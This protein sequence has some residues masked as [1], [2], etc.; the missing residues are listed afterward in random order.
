MEDSRGGQHPYSNSS[1]SSSTGQGHGPDRYPSH[2]SSSQ[3]HHYPQQQHPPS[4]FPKETRGHSLQQYPQDPDAGAA[5]RSPITP[6]TTRKFNRM[7]IHEVLDSNQQQ[8]QQHPYGYEEDSPPYKRKGSPEE[9]SFSD[10]PAS[11]SSLNSRGPGLHQQSRSQYGRGDMRHNSDYQRPLSPRFR[12]ESPMPGSN[13]DDDMDDDIRNYK[14]RRMFPG[15]PGH[16]SGSRQQSPPSTSP[17][18]PEVMD[19]VRSTLKLKQQQKAII[20]SRQLG[21]Q[22]SPQPAPSNGKPSSSNGGNPPVTETSSSGLSVF[23]G[24][25][26]FASMRGRPLPSP[27]KAK[28]AKSLTIFAPSY[29]DST[30]SIQSAPL[31][32]SQSHQAM[33]MG[34]RTS[35][36]LL[37]RHQQHPYAPQ[38]VSYQQPLRSPRTVGHA[39]KASRSALRQ[40]GAGGDGSSGTIPAPILSSHT[41]PLPS[42]MYPPST[43]FLSNPKHMFM[44]TVSNLLDSVDSGR[45]LKYTLEEQIRKSAQLLQTLQ[46]SGT[47]IENLVRGQFKEL[48]KGVLE[49]FEGEIEHLNARV[50]QLE[51]HQGLTAPP[52]KAKAATA[53]IPSTSPPTSASAMTGVTT[54]LNG[55]TTETGATSAS[56]SGTLEASNEIASSS[57]PTQQDSSSP[58]SGTLPTP[59]L[60]KNQDS[61]AMDVEE[62][63]RE[64]SEY[65][66]SVKGLQERTANLESRKD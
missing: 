57:T 63:D 25:T 23:H 53:A 14:K 66:S 47:M 17:G 37:P 16:K 40:P 18:G 43:P 15:M 55:T 36:P 38:Q 41:G 24:S 8:Q 62:E 2:S 26:S 58:N 59:P 50:R 5:W 28:N 19:Q 51:E 56:G 11:S 35:Q 21:G 27:M 3:Q 48:E 13:S 10:P 61:S 6:T 60:N 42:P 54:S 7:A 31:Q 32:P 1:S 49:R 30:L 44:E 46:A 39:K 20:E 64:S 9:F 52:K 65:D 12:H 4:S 22:P 33:S 34:L 45:S 29:S